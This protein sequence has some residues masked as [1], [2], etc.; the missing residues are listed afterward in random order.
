MSVITEVMAVYAKKGVTLM[1]IGYNH[2][3]VMAFVLNLPEFLVNIALRIQQKKNIP[4]KIDPE[5]AK[6]VGY[7]SMVYL[8]FSSRTIVVS[9]DQFVGLIWRDGEGV[10]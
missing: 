7:G 5:T 10:K 2:P 1:N 3:K 6:V 4:M 9:I 8:I